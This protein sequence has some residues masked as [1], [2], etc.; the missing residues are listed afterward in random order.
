MLEP[1][2]SVMMQILSSYKTSAIHR[3][4]NVAI[5]TNVVAG[6]VALSVIWSAV[7]PTYRNPGDS[8]TLWSQ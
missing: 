7:D 5:P 1:K 2:Q 4:H 6:V 3:W 8:F